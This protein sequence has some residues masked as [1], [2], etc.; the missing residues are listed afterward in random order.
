MPQPLADLPRAPELLACSLM[1]EYE[2]IEWLDGLA[3]E[4][5]RSR[6]EIMRELLRGLMK[7]GA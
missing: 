3:E 6:S 7:K 2:Q 5:R 4:K 1:L